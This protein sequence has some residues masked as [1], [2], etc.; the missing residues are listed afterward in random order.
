MTDLITADRPEDGVLLLTLNRPEAHNAMSIAV[1][2]DLDQ[3]ITAAA[4]DPDVRTIVLAGAGERAFSAGYDVHELTSISEDEHTLVQIEREEL[5]W[6][7]YDCPIPIITACR[8]ITYGAGALYAICSDLRVGGPATTFKVTATLYGGANL[9]WI[10]D[11]LVGTAA[12]RDILLTSRPVGGDEA[13]DLK[14]LNR[15]VPDTDVLRTS[16]ALAASIAANN[17]K[18][19]REVKRLLVTG[20]GRDT[21]ARYDAENTAMMTT[22]RPRPMTEI[23]SGFLGRKPNHQKP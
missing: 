14:L 17:P 18:A 16:I 10:L 21:R 13:F 20:P 19:V 1:Q 2:R 7:W 15:Y 3:R 4:D 8:G 12:A 23:F 5:L 6:R 9:T 11:Q 22:I